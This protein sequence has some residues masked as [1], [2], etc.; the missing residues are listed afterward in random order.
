M[1]TYTNTHSNHTD[2][3]S[4]RWPISL[5]WSANWNSTTL[6]PNA[7]KITGTMLREVRQNAKAVEAQFN[8]VGTNPAYGN[9]SD[10]ATGAGAIIN[11]SI[12]NQ[13]NNSL[14]A[15]GAGLLDGLQTMSS[16]VNPVPA[17]A[18][19]QIVEGPLFSSMAKKL[20]ALSS[21]ANYTNYANS[22]YG[23]YSNYT[24]YTKSTNYT[25]YKRYS[26]YNRGI[27]LDNDDA[28]WKYTNYGE[29]VKSDTYNNSNDPG[30]VNGDY[31]NATTAYSNAK[32]SNSYSN[33]AVYQNT[34]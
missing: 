8:F 19:G 7:T 14:T 26:E 6:A 17:V 33:P 4:K 29:H 15:G 3:A 25:D 11:R 28:S 18:T 2:D 20:K 32:Y 23:Q 31:N 16:S 30:Y 21:Y 13:A 1:S 9:A 22:G 12:M 24:Q 10:A 34:L 27:H 5:P